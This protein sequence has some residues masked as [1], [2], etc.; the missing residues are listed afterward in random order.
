MIKRKS[1][2]YLIPAVALLGLFLL[3]FAPTSGPIWLQIPLL[4]FAIS[5][6]IKAGLEYLE[7]AKADKQLQDPA[8]PNEH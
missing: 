7:E 8:P 5:N 1:V 6:F 4:A 2:R 3:S